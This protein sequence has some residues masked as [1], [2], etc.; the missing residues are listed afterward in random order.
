MINYSVMKKIV[1][2]DSYT[3]DPGDIKWDK[4]N[5]LTMP[6]G[7]KCQIEKFDR[8][9]PEDVVKRSRGAVAILTNKVIITSEIM[10]Q[11]PDLQYIG[12]LATGYNVVDI[13][14]AKKRD[15][16]VT[17]IP[18]YSTDSVAQMVFAHLLNI[19]HHVAQH[20]EAVNN[21]DWQNST[22]FC[23]W[24]SPLI[25]LAGQT[26]GIIGLGNT[27]MKTAQIALAF[28]MKVIA[29]TS[30]S[31]NVLPQGII[32]VSIDEC[33]QYADVLS[34]HCPL[35]ETTKHIVNEAHLAMMKKNAILINTGRGPLV[36]DGALAKA[37]NNK[38]I[39]AAGIDVLTEEP[40]R[41]GNPLI[42]ARNCFITPHI[43]WATQAARKRL[44]DIALDNL[45]AFFSG[46]PINVVNR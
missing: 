14:A 31:Q 39:Y 12:V 42:G 9:V 34:L 4:W 8:T 38:Q 35:T 45:K 32:A 20:A 43:A 11:L 19:T 6:N 18:A 10:T 36:D 44:I 2:L 22:D 17:N 15:I 37:L 21:G 13:E 46:A 23:F 1:I 24:K 41:N 25:E 29:V 5:D 30:K 26:M 28:G 7:E 3:S 16:I 33:F 40:P 27:G